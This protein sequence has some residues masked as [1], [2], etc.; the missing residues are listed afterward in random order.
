MPVEF[1]VQLTELKQAFRPLMAAKPRGKKA[2]LEYVDIIAENGEVSF[3]I[4]GASSSSPA[5]VFTAGYARAPFPFFEQFHRILQTMPQESVP[6]SID[7]GQIK[8]ANLTFNHEGITI[9]LIGARIADLPIDASLRETLSLLV[10]FS[11]EELEDSGLLARVM[12]AEQ[13]AAELIDRAT[14]ALEP[15]EIKRED[16]SRLVWDQIKQQLSKK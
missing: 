6:V 14:K 16:V 10:R 13:H 15:L 1:T 4:A 12:A 3:E 7:A 11:Q 9:R 2:Q 8:A 5:K